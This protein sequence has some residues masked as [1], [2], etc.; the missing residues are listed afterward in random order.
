MYRT[1]EL[2]DL[3]LVYFLLPSYRPD[4][5]FTPTLQGDQLNMA[6]FFWYLI[7]VTCPVYDSE[8]VSLDKSLNKVT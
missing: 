7:N 1:I 2:S 8:Y 6:V 3:I 4:P 5:T